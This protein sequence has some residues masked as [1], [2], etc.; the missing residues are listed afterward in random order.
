MTLKERLANLNNG[1]STMYGLPKLQQAMTGVVTATVSKSGLVTL[2]Y[3]D[4]TTESRQATADL[5]NTEMS[6]MHVNNLISFVQAGRTPSPKG[7]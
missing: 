2:T 5:L 6:T 4:D 7:E 3:T 1:A